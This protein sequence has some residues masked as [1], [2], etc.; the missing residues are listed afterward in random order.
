[1]S[2]KNNYLKRYENTYKFKVF[3]FPAAQ[4]LSVRSLLIATG[5][6][7]SR[8]CLLLGVTPAFVV[9]ILLFLVDIIK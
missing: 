3:L 2:L 6:R 1:M 7:Y 5:T 9:R 8:F 4:Y